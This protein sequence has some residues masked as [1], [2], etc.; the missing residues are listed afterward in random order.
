MQPNPLA[1]IEKM[2]LT[3]IISTYEAIPPGVLARRGSSPLHPVQVPDL[4]GVKAAAY[5][6][7]RGSFATETSAI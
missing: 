5:W 3:E 6:I 2:S 7:T 4:I 1:S